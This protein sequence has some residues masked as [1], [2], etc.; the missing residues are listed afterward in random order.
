MKKLQ[1]IKTIQLS[2][3]AEDKFDENS[4]TVYD[5]ENEFWRAEYKLK[6]ANPFVG[7]SGEEF[8]EKYFV[9]KTASARVKKGR[10]NDESEQYE[11]NLREQLKALGFEKRGITFQDE[12]VETETPD[13]LVRYTLSENKIEVFKKY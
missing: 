10:G 8:F 3:N 5:I 11:E 12:I 1:E 2:K 9:E 4:K 7:L 6:Q 13:N